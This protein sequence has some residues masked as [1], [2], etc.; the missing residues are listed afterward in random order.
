M[1]EVILQNIKVMKV[2]VIG[3]KNSAK[4]FR[5]LESKLPTLRGRKFYGCLYGAPDTGK[6]EACVALIGLDD[7]EGMGLE[8]GF[9][10]GGKYLREKVKDWTGKEH[11]IAETFKKMGREANIDFS[12]PYIEFYKSQKELILFLP[13]L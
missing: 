4:A 8:T 10:P 2:A 9:V 1:N 11:L 3:V 13:V 7:P 5:Q 12:R 6:Y